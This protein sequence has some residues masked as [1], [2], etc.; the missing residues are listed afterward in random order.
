MASPQTS[1]GGS[2]PSETGGRGRPTR[3]RGLTQ[4]GSWP[5]KGASG[6]RMSNHRELLQW[7]SSCSI[8]LEF[9]YQAGPGRLLQLS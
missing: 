9:V 6:A 5:R 2:S 3:A 1:L 7:L 4:N 8:R